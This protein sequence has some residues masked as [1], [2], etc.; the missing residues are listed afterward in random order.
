MGPLPVLE[1]PS[2]QQI[3]HDVGQA[4][5]H[6]QMHRWVW[7]RVDWFGLPGESAAATQKSLF[8]KIIEMN[9]RWE[10]VDVGYHEVPLGTL[11]CQTRDGEW[12]ITV[13]VEKSG[14][15]EIRATYTRSHP[16]Q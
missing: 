4:T 2:L 6:S 14:W 16:D 12:K 15:N 1:M 13:T 3:L 8:V 10:K 11:V 7:L 9:V 5:P